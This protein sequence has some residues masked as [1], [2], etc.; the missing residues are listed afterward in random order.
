M[1]TRYNQLINAVGSINKARPYLQF[2][3]KQE[4]QDAISEGARF[5]VVDA[6]KARLKQDK[7]Y[8]T[9]KI[10]CQMLDKSNN[11]IN[12]ETGVSLSVIYRRKKIINKYSYLVNA[13]IRSMD[14]DMLA[15]YL[16]QDATS[17][18]IERQKAII[19]GM[20]KSSEVNMTGLRWIDNRIRDA[21]KI[22]KK[23][24]IQSLL[25]L[26]LAGIQI[27]TAHRPFCYGVDNVV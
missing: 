17:K 14:K 25:M 4:L 10:V 2:L 24:D 20:Y 19:H 22:K 16:T 3:T 12:R 11:E 15:V 27:E 6:Y 23:K 21:R 7:Y 26:P 13:D 5:N 9:T 1:S 8:D 18:D